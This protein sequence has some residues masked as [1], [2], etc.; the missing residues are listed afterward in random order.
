MKIQEKIDFFGNMFTIDKQEC[1]VTTVS[2]P[3]IARTWAKTH[4]FDICSHLQ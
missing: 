2:Q 1:T 3:I 4:F